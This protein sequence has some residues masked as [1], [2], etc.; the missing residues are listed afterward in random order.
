MKSGCCDGSGR[1]SR[2]ARERE[3]RRF[4][5]GMPAKLSLLP[6]MS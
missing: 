1:R 4:D 3:R 5:G 2:P 6:N